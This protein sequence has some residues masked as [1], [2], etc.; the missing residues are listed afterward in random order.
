[1]LLYGAPGTGKTTLIR[2]LAQKLLRENYV[3]SQIIDCR[4]EWRGL[5]FQNLV[6]KWTDRLFLGLLFDKLVKSVKD[7]MNLLHAR[8]PSVLILD[9]FDFH[10]WKN[11][12]E[13]SSP[14]VEVHSKKVYSSMLKGKIK[15]CSVM[16][17]K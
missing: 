11:P 12:E 5:S 8:A 3:F 7:T 9:N 10:E 17:M 15:N 6:Q 1:M 4:S 2:I 16:L 14:E 13:N